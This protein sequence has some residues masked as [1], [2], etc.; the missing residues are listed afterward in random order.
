MTPLT[1]KQVRR[2]RRWMTIVLLGLFVFLIGV[3]PDLIGMDR[4]PVVGFVQIGVWLTGLAVLLLG[5]YATIRVIRN[6]IPTSLRAD[7]GLR[8]ISTGYVVAGVASL[9]DFIGVG[10]QRMPFI[11]FG[12]VQ[13]IGLVTGVLLSLLGIVL[14]WPLGSERQADAGQEPE[15]A[16]A[17]VAGEQEPS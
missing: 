5:A 1:R 16:S 13:V 3:W 4:S 14:Y 15:D 7:I 10:A 2:A 8:L 9:A 17:E 6:G 12:P 11:T